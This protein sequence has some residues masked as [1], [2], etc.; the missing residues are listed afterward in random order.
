MSTLT[1]NKNL[2]LSKKKKLSI[3]FLI[4]NNF[5]QTVL[6]QYILCLCNSQECIWENSASFKRR[7]R[8]SKLIKA[9]G[10]FV[11]SEEAKFEFD[12]TTNWQTCHWLNRDIVCLHQLALET[13]NQLWII[14][15]P[16]NSENSAFAALFA[17]SSALF[18]KALWVPIWK[19]QVLQVPSE[20]MESA[21]KKK[22]SV[23][24][25]THAHTPKQTVLGHISPRH[26]NCCAGGGGGGGATYLEMI[27]LLHFCLSLLSL[28]LSLVVLSTESGHS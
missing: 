15:S 18:E 2:V 9:Y 16:E 17:L 6:R 28:S 1:N 27:S 20:D 26:G 3:K 13:S 8:A 10:S 19:S 14:N 24:P 12:L 4:N 11:K 23:C 22:R 7:L 21:K 5:D 25:L